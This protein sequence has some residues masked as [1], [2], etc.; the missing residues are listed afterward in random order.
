MN[1]RDG[2]LL[3]R[4]SNLPT[5]RANMLAGMVLACG[6][7]A[8]SGLALVGLAFT[9]V[10]LGGMCFNDAF[11]ADIDA[12]EHPERPIP[13]GRTSRQTVYTAGYSMLFAGLGFL[14]YL[15]HAGAHGLLPLWAGIALALAIVT[16]DAYHKSNPLSPLIM[17]L[18]RMLVYVAAG[19]L[20]AVQLGATLWLEAAACLA[21]LIG[22]TY[23]AKQENLGAGQK[24]VAA[25]V[26][27]C[28]NHLWFLCRIRGGLAGLD[29]AVWA[30][31]RLRFV[32]RRRPGDIPR[33]VVS[34]VVGISLLD[35]RLIA[36][37]GQSMLALVAVTSFVLTLLL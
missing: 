6:I 9:L 27:W 13:A 24:P 31:V 20:V 18:C 16:Y 37:A 11:D 33:A 23:V 12:E 4:V 17:G 10:Y 36:G 14:G 2:L 7:L 29:L 34:L 35:A 8:L 22:L 21:W 15:A 3:G 19:A 28:A 25:C 30:L 32:V 5:V 1:L 26:S